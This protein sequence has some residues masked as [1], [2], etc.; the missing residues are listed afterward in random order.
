MKFDIDM[1][2]FWA[3]ISYFYFKLSILLLIVD[4]STLFYLQFCQF[5]IHSIRL[6]W[7]FVIDTLFAYTRVMM[8]SSAI[9][10][11]TWYCH[12]CIYVHILLFYFFSF[13]WRLQEINTLLFQILCDV[14]FIFKAQV[15]ALK[16][17]ALEIKKRGYL[18]EV[19]KIY[20]VHTTYNYITF[21]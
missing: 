18:R 11:F 16:K 12:F 13:V 2:I 6:D 14:Y 15:Q 7:L 8:A 9:F 1:H 21:S 17:S 19:G 5:P 3:S 10:T 4:V 20:L